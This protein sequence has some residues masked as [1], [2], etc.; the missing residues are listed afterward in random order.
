MPGEDHFTAPGNFLDQWILF[1]LVRQFSTKNFNFYIFTFYPS[2]IKFYPTGVHFWT[3]RFLVLLKNFLDFLLLCFLGVALLKIV[4]KKSRA[5]HC[6][7]Y[8]VYFLPF[9]F[10]RMIRSC[11]SRA[12]E[13]SN[14]LY[15]YISLNDIVWCCSAVVKS[16]IIYIF[17]IQ[18]RCLFFIKN[19]CYNVFLIRAEQQKRV[20]TRF[21]ILSAVALRRATHKYLCVLI[22]KSRATMY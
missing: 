18:W 3:T 9:P 8:G 2:V 10:S 20:T 19:I 14:A 13:Q 22:Q 16:I 6:N 12:T 4:Y 1:T 11:K 17:L 15:P 21:S 7:C 5:T